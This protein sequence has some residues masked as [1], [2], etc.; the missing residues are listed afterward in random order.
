MFDFIETPVQ[1][2]KVVIL[3]MM[4][5]CFMALALFSEFTGRVVLDRTYGEDQ[6]LSEQFED[7]SLTT[8]TLSHPTVCWM[9]ISTPDVYTGT[10]LDGGV[11]LL[12]EEWRVA[13][14]STFDF[15]PA[16]NNEPPLIQTEGY[17]L[18]PK[19]V[20]SIEAFTIDDTIAQTTRK[21]SIHVVMKTHVWMMRHYI[22]GLIASLVLLT[23]YI[24]LLY[25]ATYR[26]P[27]YTPTHTS[28]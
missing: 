8:F 10:H 6:L 11:A 9:K 4:A 18:L 3:I 17:F 21:D 24:L 12:D 23:L 15:S 27:S 28:V 25:S 5:M 16:M 20:Y 22:V 13:H 26:P 7:A 14:V 19:G 1:R 2:F